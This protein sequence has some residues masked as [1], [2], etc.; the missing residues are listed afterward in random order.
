MNEKRDARSLR[1]AGR[2]PAF[3][4]SSI[5]EEPVWVSLAWIIIPALLAGIAIFFAVR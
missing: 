3:W 1:H 2:P 4:R 5:Y